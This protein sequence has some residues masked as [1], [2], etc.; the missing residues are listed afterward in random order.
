MIDQKGMGPDKMG[1]RGE[2]AGVQGE[3]TIIRI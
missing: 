2:V 1:G 3:G